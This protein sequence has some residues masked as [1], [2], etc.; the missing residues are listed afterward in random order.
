MI[1]AGIIKAT[2]FFILL[3]AFAWL[4][5]APGEDSCPACEPLKVSAQQLFDDYQMDEKAADKNY[6]GQLVLVYGTVIDVGKGTDGDAYITLK[7]GKSGGVV[8]TLDKH[9]SEATDVS[10]GQAI[11]LEGIVEGND[12]EGNVLVN[13]AILR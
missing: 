13:G 11:A 12:V 9:T 6:Q 4:T 7:G 1:N 2:G 3:M 5:M 8:S 10:A